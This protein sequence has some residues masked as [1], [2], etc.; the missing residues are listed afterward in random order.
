M[1]RHIS[2]TVS[3]MEITYL[4]HALLT[5]TQEE[6]LISQINKFLVYGLLPTSIIVTNLAE[7][8]LGKK[9]NKN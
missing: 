5:R 8:I 3:P 9:I 4:Y 6:A 1:R 7:E 2:K